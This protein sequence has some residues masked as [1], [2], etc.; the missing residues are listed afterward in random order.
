MFLSFDPLREPSTSVTTCLRPPPLLHPSA[1][2]P[3][4]PNLHPRLPQI[5]RSQAR[6]PNICLRKAAA[7]PTPTS[8][9][10]R[11]SSSLTYRASAELARACQSTRSC[12]TR[13]Q[14]GLLCGSSEKATKAFP[15]R[16]AEGG[17]HPVRC[18]QPNSTK[19]FTCVALERDSSPECACTITAL[20]FE[21]ALLYRYFCFR[22]AGS[23]TY[24]SSHALPTRSTQRHSYRESC[25]EN[26][27]CSSLIQLD[28]T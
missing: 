28:G 3:P 8:S 24:L 15:R 9:A 13:S 5:H 11:T 17:R 4:V 1:V 19:R 25:G 26:A 14:A 23:Q 7:R 10:R 22:I 12:R 6:T 2:T 18:E 21:S 20:A 27:P 16:N